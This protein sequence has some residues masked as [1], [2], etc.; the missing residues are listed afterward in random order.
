M[1]ENQIGTDDSATQQQCPSDERIGLLLSGKLPAEEQKVL[2][3]H[4]MSC[5]DCCQ[6]IAGMQLPGSEKQKS[7][8]SRNSSLLVLLGIAVL[9]LIAILVLT[10]SLPRLKDAAQA[11]GNTMPASANNLNALRGFASLIPYREPSPGH[12]FPIYK[13]GEKI[14]VEVHFEQPTQ[15]GL[16]FVNPKGLVQQLFPNSADAKNTPLPSGRNILPERSGAMPLPGETGAAYFFTVTSSVSP[17]PDMEFDR[18]S[19]SVESAAF[20]KNGTELYAAIDKALS[21]SGWKYQILSL[22]ITR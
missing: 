17:M 5:K 2:V 14:S 15:I 9:G 19:H 21:Q 16:F 7:F 11:V 8:A 20:S 1:S 10:F 4:V 18:V 22:E 3:G 13:V 6:W 12:V